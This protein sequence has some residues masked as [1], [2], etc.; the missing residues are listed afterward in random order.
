MAQQLREHIA[1]VEDIYLV[2]RTK[3]DGSQPPVTPILER[4]RH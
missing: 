2:S 3:S 1:V 4:I